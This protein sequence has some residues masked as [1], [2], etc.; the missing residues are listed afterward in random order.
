MRFFTTLFLA[1]LW[2]ASAQAQTSIKFA[3]DWRFEGPATPYFVALDKGYYKAEGLDVTI[4]PG[5]GSV[6]GAWGAQAR[7]ATIEK[8]RKH[9]QNKFI[10]FQLRKNSLNPTKNMPCTRSIL[11]RD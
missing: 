10:I 6:E 9:L 1:G 8:R 11:L 5:S 7:K 2:A 3:L 4:D